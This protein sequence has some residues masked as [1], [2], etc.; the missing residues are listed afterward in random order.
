MI[1]KKYIY[2]AETENDRVLKHLKNYIKE[3]WPVAKS[4]VA[5]HIRYFWKYKQDSFVTDDLIFLK[6][7]IFVPTALRGEVLNKLHSA[8]LGTEKTKARA[9]ALVYWPS[10][11]DDMDD[12]VQKCKLCQKYR[13]KSKK[14]PMISHE[15]SDIPFHKIGMD[16]MEVDGKNY[17]II[18]DYYTKYLEI[19]PVKKKIR[20]T[21][22][23][24]LLPLFTTHGIPRIIIVDNVPFGSF[25][26]EQF[27]NNFDISIV[28]TSSR[29]PR[30]NGFAEHMV[31]VA[32]NL[33]LKC[34]ED[35]SSLWI[36]LLKY[37]N[38]PIKNSLLSPTELMGRKTRSQIPG[39]TTMFKNERPSQQIKPVLFRNNK[40]NELNYDTTTEIKEEFENGDA[41]WVKED[42]IWVPGKI[43]YKHLKSP[44]SYWIEL[45]DGRTLRRNS[46]FF[47][48][49]RK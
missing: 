4:K 47:L 1:K 35:K 5:E 12:M 9:R 46:F 14:E 29:Y 44:R 24:K 33:I 39:K 45:V 11:N 28:K 25:E 22:I 37:R 15:I 16:F 6:D 30:S 20:Q 2:K 18:A 26:F 21:V 31:Q 41:I 36:A 8:H 34:R 13:P 32:R 42:K 10:L 23:Q 7:R 43:K 49:P 38:T 17:L 19:L 48:R 27:C 3:G 40:Q